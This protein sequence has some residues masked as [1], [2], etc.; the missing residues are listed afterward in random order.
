[1]SPSGR[2]LWKSRRHWVAAGFLLSTSLFLLFVFL[3]WHNERRGIEQSAQTGLSS[4]ADTG[5]RWLQRSRLGATGMQTAVE[6][7]AARADRQIVRTATLEIVVADPSRT[8]EQLGDMASQ[9]SG[10]VVSS[11]TSGEERNAFVG[12]NPPHSCATLR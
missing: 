1:M 3:I 9:L 12:G 2:A 4:V 7:A 10:F 8:A 6:P 5:P 11:K